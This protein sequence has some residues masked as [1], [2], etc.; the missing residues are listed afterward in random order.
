MTYEPNLPPV[1]C[2]VTLWSPNQT[3]VDTGMQEC[4]ADLTFVWENEIDKS[5]T[6]TIRWEPDSDQL[7]ANGIIT[8]SRLIPATDLGMFYVPGVNKS[9]LV[10]RY[11]GPL[12]FIVWVQ[13]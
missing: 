2:Q 8:A 5:V 3:L 12:N 6:F 4:A 9:S 13:E 1:D 11:D 7:Q 10:Q